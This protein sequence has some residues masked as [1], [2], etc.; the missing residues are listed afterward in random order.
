MK[1]GLNMTMSVRRGIVKIGR[2][3]LRLLQAIIRNPRRRRLWLQ[4][5]LLQMLLLL[6]L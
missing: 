6:L 1:M 5:L 4:M 2:R 3:R